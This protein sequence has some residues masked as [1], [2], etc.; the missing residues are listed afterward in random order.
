MRIM[1]QLFFKIWETIK[2]ILTCV[3]SKEDQTQNSHVLLFDDIDLLGAG[4]FVLEQGFH[5]EMN[6][7]NVL[8]TWSVCLLRL[9]KGIIVFVKKAYQD[10]IHWKRNKK[11]AILTLLSSIPCR[12]TK[13][14]K[15]CGKVFIFV[16]T[17]GKT[18]MIT[19]SIP[20]TTTST[21]TMI[22]VIN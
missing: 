6:N 18:T 10:S 1:Q 2:K 22:T 5:L 4:E 3:C 14:S 8:N 9:D 15:A 16:G 7:Y 13:P 11:L 12:S 21:K 17:T 20:T 19:I